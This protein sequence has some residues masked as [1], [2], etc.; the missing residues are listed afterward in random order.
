MTEGLP[1]RN[2]LDVLEDLVDKSMLLQDREN[3]EMR[4]SLLQTLREFG[5]ERLSEAGE[6]EAT[7]VAHSTYFLSWVERIAPMLLGAEQA[8]WL[9]QLDREYENVRVALEWMLDETGKDIERAE[10]ALRLCVALMAFWEIRGY[11]AEGLVFMERALTVGK[12]A[13]PSVK[14]QALHYAGF[15]AL[16]Q[17]DNTRAEA[18]LRESQILFRESG[19]KAGMA[20]ILRLQGNLAMI[21]N[22]YKIAR[23]L[24]EEALNIYRTLGDIQ[25]SAWTREALVQIAI[26]QGDYSNIRLRGQ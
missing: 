5:L 22:N 1:N 4:F 16:M 6:L 9:D 11:I 26:R 14:A 21:K 10:Q 23:R 25:R 13:A 12:D 3:D 20:N 18:F 17:D 7:R 15:L 2:I 8:H 19:D 24:L